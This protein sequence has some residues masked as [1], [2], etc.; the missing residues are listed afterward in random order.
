MTKIRTEMT[1][2]ITYR[3]TEEA[4]LPQ[5]RAINARYI[6]NTS[7]TLKRAVPPLSSFL[8]K[9][10]S[11]QAR[12]LPHLVAVDRPADGA[13][14]RVLGYACLSPY[15]SSHPP[16]TELSLFVHPDHQSRAVGSALLARV[17]ARVRAEE[18]VH[19]WRDE[20]DADGVVV[21]TVVRSVIAVM[22]VDPEGKEGGEALRRFYAKRGFEE[23]GRL[24]KAGLKRGHW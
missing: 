15:R 9:H 18:V 11:L 22:A 19:R 1:E 13:E 8:T 21:P 7:I 17:L 23:R 20:N 14:D 6:L 4:D 5:I 16:T 12:G 2:E 24:V 10:Q 3:P